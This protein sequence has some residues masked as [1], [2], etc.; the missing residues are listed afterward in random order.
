M[1]TIQRCKCNIIKGFQ[2]E[3]GQWIS[4]QKEIVQEIQCFY[5]NLFTISRPFNL[6]SILSLIHLLVDNPINDSLI[7]NVTNEEI[8]NAKFDMHPLKAPGVDSMTPFFSKY[9]NT[10]SGNICEEV[11]S[12]FSSGHLIHSWDQTLIALIPKIKN[13]SDIS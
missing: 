9:W 5:K 10:L 1:K 7:R 11:K 6:D 2:L 8:K 12:F 4:K 13:P 3:Y